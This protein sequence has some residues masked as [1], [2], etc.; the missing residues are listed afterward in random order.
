MDI[1][2]DASESDASDIEKDRARKESLD[3]LQSVSSPTS[4]VAFVEQQKAPGL[5]TDSSSNKIQKSRTLRR[6]KTKGPDAVIVLKEE[7]VYTNACIIATF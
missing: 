3:K 7:K 6:T 2:G 5:S 4:S 1:R